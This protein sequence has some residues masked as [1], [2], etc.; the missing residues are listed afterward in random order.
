[1]RITL[2]AFLVLLRA[3]YALLLASHTQRKSPR[4]T[5]MCLLTLYPF[6]IMSWGMQLSIRCRYRFLAKKKTQRM[7]Y[8]F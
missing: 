6:F 8:P 1:M 4:A 2:L 3:G 7:F 5:P